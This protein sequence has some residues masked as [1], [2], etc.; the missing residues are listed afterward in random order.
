MKM[1]IDYN[2]ILITAMSNPPQAERRW[3]SL[4]F[5][6]KADCNRIFIAVI[7]GRKGVI[8]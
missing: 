7:T 6:A 2:R 3:R 8:E 1:K 5:S 4:D